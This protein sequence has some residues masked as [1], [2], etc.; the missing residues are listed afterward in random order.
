MHSK[1][2]D[3]EKKFLA[4]FLE[5]IAE[6]TLELCRISYSGNVGEKEILELSAVLSEKTIIS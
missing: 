1:P 5:Q 2:D 4:V 3:T 6:K